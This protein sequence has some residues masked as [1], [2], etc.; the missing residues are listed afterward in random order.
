MTEAT[1]TSSSGAGFW[2][3]LDRTRAWFVPRYMR[4][5]P[6]T[7]GLFRILVGALLCL[8][9]VRHWRFADRYYS[10]VGVL[11]NHWH[12]YT[13]SGD[14]NFSL[15]HAFS[16]LGEVHVAFAL[17]FACYLAFAL[18]YKTRLATVLSCLWVTSMDNR[19]V[20][21]E[22][23][24]YVVVNLTVFW[25][26]FLPLG[27]RFSLDALIAS[28]RQR[29]EATID[30]LN[31]GV[32]R[33]VRPY[34]SLLSFVVVL[35]FAIIYI[36]NVVNKYGSTWRTGKTAHF[37]LHID[38][39]VTLPAVWL[40]E[41]LPFPLLQLASWLV[42]VVEAVIVMA[43]LWPNNRLRARPTAWVLIVLLH[44][45]FG[46]LMRL[47]P[48]SWFMIAFSSITVMACH[49]EWLAAWHAKRTPAVTLAFDTT[50]GAGWWLCR[51]LERLDAN[52]RIRFEAASG[53]QLLSLHDGSRTHHGS[54]AV[55][56]AVSVLPGGRLLGPTLRVASLGLFDL[57]V[58]L[59]TRH[60]DA[61]S[62]F[63]ALPAPP[64]R[65][66][67]SP[68]AA[69]PLRQ[70]VA[71]WLFRLHEL[72][73]V[74]LVLCAASQIINENK[75]VPK[76]LKHQAPS[77]MRATVGYPRIFQGWGMFA[78]NP[79]RED[80]VMAVDAITV[81]GRHVDPFTGREPDL[82]LS[83]ARGAGLDQI[84]QDYQNRIRLERNKVYRRELERWILRYPER[85][86]RPEDEIVFFNVYWLVD[87]NPEPGSSTPFDHQ[88]LC[89]LS[90]KKRGARPKPPLEPLPDKCKVVSTEKKDEEKE[91]KDEDERQWWQRA[92]TF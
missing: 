13:P 70:R 4:L 89:I 52:D 66:V 62:R 81:D 27:R 2:A 79:I 88:R 83:D 48:F 54:A 65:L 60:P 35:N 38:R 8:D 29:R 90:Y 87:Q 50:S 78:P 37:V 63:F 1:A 73:V 68:P 67:A 56:R 36:F 45:S 76:V 71:R 61:W 24:G 80:G 39:M 12:L 3:R 43:L 28:W 44:G 86:G 77:F 49:W 15:F 59:L 82:N 85:T 31:D 57:V 30:D 17:S 10:N 69:S 91:D 6:R 74:Y 14:Y 51:L 7:L 20:M 34:V 33:D 53:S 84:E 41:L 72:V 40:R 64:P 75:S 25:G 11:S 47:G 22:N 16:S 18:G 42:L 23:G 92:L 46:V 21:V 55:H 32:A 9:C 5:D 19:L 26:M 58:A